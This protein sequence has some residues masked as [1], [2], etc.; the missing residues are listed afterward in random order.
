MKYLIVGLGNIGN[1]Y[2]NTRHNIG[3]QIL[4]KLTQ[5]TNTSF[6]NGRYADVAKMKYKSRNL[7]LIKPTTLMNV[8][9][10]AVNYWM[11]K[12]HIPINNILILVDDVAL[13]F[14]TLR[15]RAKGSSGGHNGLAN[16]EYMISSSQYPRLRFGIGN[17]FP[18][19][20]QINYVLGNWE[21]SELH[22]LPER[23][24]CAI[25]YIYSFVSI[26]LQRTQNIGL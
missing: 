23:I 10:K 20:Q 5:D 22:L 11:N 8:S 25:E 14:G 6:E 2:R 1:K 24:D 12:E 17:D 18:K 7:I 9:G 26:G 16:I 13:P 19:G 4:D 15:L 21:Q 3:F